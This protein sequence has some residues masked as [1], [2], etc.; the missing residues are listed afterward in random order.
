MRYA[1]SKSGYSMATTGAVS[2]AFQRKGLIVIAGDAIEEDKLFEL[3]IEAGAEDLEQEDGSF[4]ITTDPAT[5][6]DVVAALEGAEIAM[7]S[8]ELSLLPDNYI[9]VSDAKDAEQLLGFIEKL[10][11]LDDV[12]DVYNNADIDSAVLEK[13]AAEG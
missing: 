1:F 3:A 9:P 10:E 12:Q 13:L 6:M 4:S 2:P 7:Q 5:F 8:S 11:D